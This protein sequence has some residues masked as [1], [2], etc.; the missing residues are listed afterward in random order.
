MRVIK[1]GR[2]KREGIIRTV[3]FECVNCDCIFEEDTMDLRQEG[4]YICPCP[5]CEREVWSNKYKDTK[6][7]NY[8]KVGDVE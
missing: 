2:I 1:H 7:I 3:T 4:V 5:D 6:Y 8:Y